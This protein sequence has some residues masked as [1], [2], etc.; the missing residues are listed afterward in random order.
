MTAPS[1]LTTTSQPF[2]LML[3]IRVSVSQF[4]LPENNF[5]YCVLGGHSSCVPGRFC[6]NELSFYALSFQVLISI[7][8]SSVKL[9]GESGKNSCAPLIVCWFRSM[10]SCVF[11]LKRGLISINQTPLCLR[12]NPERVQYRK[13][14]Q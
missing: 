7:H 6:M 4:L 13:Q 10:S 5:F 12:Q 2:S 14:N 8:C 9:L 11:L 3:L 1:C